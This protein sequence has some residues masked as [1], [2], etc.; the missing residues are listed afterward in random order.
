MADGP[1]S[2]ISEPSGR[3]YVVVGSFIDSDLAEDKAN[4]IIKSGAQA[5][6]LEP[7]GEEI[8]YR[9]GVNGANDYATANSGIDE[10]KQTFGTEIWVLKY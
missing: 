1:N 10:L 5:Y 2:A 9:V 6:L 4:A 3:F 7:Q 8:Y